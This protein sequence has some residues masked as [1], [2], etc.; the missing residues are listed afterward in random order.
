M[1]IEKILLQT[2]GETIGQSTLQN[3]LSDMYLSPA[4]TFHQ[5]AFKERIDELAFAIK[6][7]DQLK[8]RNRFPPCP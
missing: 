2:I 5:T 7:L 8:V 1:C 3:S 6:V 4:F